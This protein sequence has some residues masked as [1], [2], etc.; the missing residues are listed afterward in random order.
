MRAVYG[1]LYPEQ[2]DFELEDILG[3]LEVAPELSRTADDSQ[4]NAA[5]NGLDTGAM[6]HQE[7]TGADS[8]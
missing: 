1:R 8:A 7:S 4:R 6:R 5:L 2:P 3:L